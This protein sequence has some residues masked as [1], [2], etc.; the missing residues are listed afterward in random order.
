MFG[1]FIGMPILVVVFLL[2]TKYFN[3]VSGI[4]NSVGLLVLLFIFLMT[5]MFLLS[6][7]KKKYSKVAHGNLIE[8]G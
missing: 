3:L 6:G 2:I 5:S 8:N 7:G 4:L 1:Q